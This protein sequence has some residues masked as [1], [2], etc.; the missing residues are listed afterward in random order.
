ME[1]VGR[2]VTGSRDAWSVVPGCNSCLCAGLA[3]R[4]VARS[5]LLRQ[6]PPSHPHL[7]AA[8]ATQRSARRAKL[9][10]FIVLCSCG[11]ME[12]GG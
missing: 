3:D 9:R 1:S 8:A 5:P 7:S 12:W 2:E 11:R 6:P 4:K 10:V